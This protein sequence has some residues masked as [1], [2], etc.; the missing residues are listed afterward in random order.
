LKTGLGHD[1]EIGVANIN[2]L[3]FSPYVDGNV[4]PSQPSTE[5]VRVPTVFGSSK[6]SDV[7]LIHL[8]D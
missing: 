6:F 4:I 7:N 1:G 5:G 3:Q 8:L 2:T